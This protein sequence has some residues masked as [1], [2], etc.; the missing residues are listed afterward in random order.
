MS[1]LSPSKPVID[2]FAQALET[3]PVVMLNLLK[4]KRGG[5]SKDYAAYAKGFESLLQK[6]G[7]RFIYMGRAAERLVGHEDWDAVAL[8][9][10]PSRKA[11]AD[12]MNSPEYAKIAPLR[13]HG[14]ERTVLYATDPRSR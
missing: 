4:F 13:E 11:F 5:G 1:S 6:A 8:V 2:A 12:V 10:Y 3:G 7:G 9:E 14:L